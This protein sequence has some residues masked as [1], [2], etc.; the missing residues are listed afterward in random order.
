MRPASEVMT[1]RSSAGNS[2]GLSYDRMQTPTGLL[3]MISGRKAQ[4][5]FPLP[6]GASG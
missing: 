1:A 2:C 6:N 3:E 4:A 5:F